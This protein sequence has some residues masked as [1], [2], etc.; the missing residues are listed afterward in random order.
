MLSVGPAETRLVKT[1]QPNKH[2]LA[3]ARAAAANPGH[4]G[5]AAGCVAGSHSIP[6]SS[7]EKRRLNSCLHSA[8]RP[9]DTR[10][11][12]VNPRFVH[13]LDELGKNPQE[14][15]AKHGDDPSVAA[16]LRSLSGLLGTH[17][18]ELGKAERQPQGP[19]IEEALRKQATG[20]GK[21]IDVTERA[22]ETWARERAEQAAAEEVIC[23]EER[24]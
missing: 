11:A 1:N 3:D 18:E 9:C 10:T 22:P 12:F 19:L 23:R 13:L 15:L 6:I 21:I 7:N 8:T 2:R 16:F 5:A 20:G 17:F 4:A 24:R 14:V